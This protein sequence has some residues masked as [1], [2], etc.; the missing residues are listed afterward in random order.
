[1][2]LFSK[3]FGKA[4]PAEGRLTAFDREK[5]QE[6]W[7]WVEDQIAIGKLNN[8]KLAIIEADKIVDELL[9]VIYPNQETMG[10]RLKLAKTQF[11]DLKT[12]DDLWYSHRIR[13][14]LV[15]ETV[16]LPSVEAV[17]I[18]GKYKKALEELAAI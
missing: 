18:L 5:A 9:K 11:G 14:A 6:R 1:M 8:L 4:Q 7:Q 16:D 10:A 2:S 3:L 12:Y 17:S 13:N 15:H